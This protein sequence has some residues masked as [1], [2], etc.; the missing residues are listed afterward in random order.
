M[1]NADQPIRSNKDDKLKRS[2]FAKN[3]AEAIL[4]YSGDS[5]FCIGIYGEWGSGKTSLLNMIIEYVQE[6]SKETIVVRFN[7]WLCS[8][9]KQMLSQF[10]KQLASEMKM[11]DKKSDK[12]CQALDRYGAWFDMAAFIPGIGNVVTTIAKATINQASKHV[13][14]RE[15]LQSQ[16]DEITKLLI[17]EKTKIIVSID[18][19]DRLSQEEIV[20][21]FQLVKSLGDFP[22]TI[23]LL[24][25][26]YDVVV[27]ALS[28]VQN[29]NGRAYLEKIVQVPFGIPVPNTATINQALFDDLN[30]IL[31]NVDDERFDNVL[32][33]E[34]F[35]YG[36]SKYIHSI[37]DV[38]R[39]VNVISLKYSLLK[40][41]TALVDLLGIICLQV[42]EPQVYSKMHFYAD[43]LCGSPY[44]I[45][46]FQQKQDEDK[47]I[48]ESIERLVSVDTETINA[49]A[50]KNIIALLFPKA[51]HAMQY[52][53]S[54]SYDHIS[55]LRNNKVAETNCFTRYFSLSLEDDAIP[56]SVIQRLFHEADKTE[57]GQIIKECN[58]TGRTTQLLQKL[59]AHI[60]D[61]NLT[62][63]KE[64]QIKDII[65]EL[66]KA[67]PG[68]EI[69]V[70]GLI[71]YPLDRKVQ[72]CIVKLLSLIN[73]DNRYQCI[74]TIF[75]DNSIQ[76]SSIAR[77]LERFESQ[78]G[79]FFEDIKEEDMKSV[80]I[81]ELLELEQILKDRA[82]IVIDNHIAI[83]QKKGL[84]F[85][86]ILGKIDEEYTKS[87]KK[88]L[89]TDDISLT[90]VISYC[91]SSG[92]FAA[93]TIYNTRHV[94]IKLLSE[95]ID[96][97]TAYQRIKQFISFPEFLE[98]EDDLQINAVAFILQYE[99]MSGDSAVEKSIAEELIKK[100]I[101][102]IRNME[103]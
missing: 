9:S 1:I 83:N 14:R 13:K 42:F 86:W 74:K 88:K 57:I 80:S 87:I 50:A 48:K 61:K 89:I 19:I 25:F 59:D 52:Q 36:V 43:I 94:Q 45:F 95:F 17:D 34:L 2:P 70:K 47:R 81:R 85:L 90:R 91:T 73:D 68:L 4:K 69:S 40:D 56:S 28:K 32:W 10:F 51:G 84:E 49:D 21:V 72:D 97:D 102:K 16:K 23:Y 3:L 30:Q 46:N 12:I 8:D 76:V 93:R 98:L 79:R 35:Y 64:P 15:N 60:S 71:G 75:F 5:S 58:S 101:D 82:V 31:G 66:L 100:E 63:Y 62:N 53:I 99:K 7:P 18:D 24:A 11:K 44:T 26:D 67:W 96:V 54:P 103:K 41:E 37:R 65:T 78:H 29:G 38:I 77:L 92:R 27:N 33:N 20:S 55:Y 22:N 39:Y 6:L